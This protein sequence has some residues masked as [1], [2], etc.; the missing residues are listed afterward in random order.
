MHLSYD[1]TDL[2]EEVESDIL[3]GLIKKDDILLIVR[4]QEE[5]FEGYYPIIDYYYNDN[6]PDEVVEMISVKK[7]LEEMQKWNSIL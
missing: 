6:S 7:V 3:E 4:G 1:Y 2:I 5:V